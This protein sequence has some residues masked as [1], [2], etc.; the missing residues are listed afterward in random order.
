MGLLRARR[1]DPVEAPIAFVDRRLGSA[2]FTKQVLSY[3]FPDHWSFL[4]GEIALYSFVVLIGTGTFLA[5]FFADSQSETVYHG[6]YSALTGLRA[7]EAYVSVL[8]ISFDVPAGLLIRQTHHWAAN[9]FVAAIVIH[10]MR[11]FFTGAF[12]KPREINYVVGVTLAMLAILEAFAGYMLPDDLLSGMGLVIAYAV[13]LSLPLIGGQFGTLVW[14]GEFPGS[15]AFWP[16]LFIAHVFLLPLIIAALIGLHLALMTRQK[17]SQFPGRGRTERNDVGTPL[18]PGYALRTVGWFLLIAGILFLL[19]GLVQINPIWQWGPYEPYLSSNGAQPDWYLGWLIGGLRLMPELEPRFGGH[20]WIPNPFWGGALFPLVVFGL[21]Y[22]W[23]WIEQR[24]IT[25]DRRRHE[26][27]DRPR[28]NP[29]RTAIGAGVLTWIVFI[30]YGGAADRVLVS[31]GFDYVGQIWAYRVLA[32]ALPVLVGLL[33]YRICRELKAREVHPLRG[34]QGST[35]TR[36]VDGGFASVPDEDA[37][38]P[39]A[40]DEPGLRR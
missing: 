14:D 17:H 22:L 36:T 38:N 9:V 28:D 27:L 35:V 8:N 6:S 37:A 2:S 5:L 20:T 4:L 32:F 34:W 23:P 21:L 24:F 25:R 33:A 16:R 31:V 7:S 3:V 26:L 18:W 11:V 30:F 10:A 15:A 40:G 39:R 13:A 1:R 19:G 12:R 29:L